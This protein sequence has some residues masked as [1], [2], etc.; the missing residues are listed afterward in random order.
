VAPPRTRLRATCGTRRVC[1]H[2]PCGW[3]VARRRR[4]RLGSRD[5]CRRRDSNSRHADYDSASLW[6]SH[7]KTRPRWT[8]SWT[9][10]RSR[11]TLPAVRRRERTGR[12]RPHHFRGQSPRR[13]RTGDNPRPGVPRPWTR[14]RRLALCPLPTPPTRR[15]VHLGTIS[16]TRSGRSEQPGTRSPHHDAKRVARAITDLAAG[17]LA[18]A[19]SRGGRPHAAGYWISRRTTDMNRMTPATTHPPMITSR[20][21]PGARRSS[22]RLAR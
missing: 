3:S 9:Q 16:R 13:R 5:R 8:R 18:L 15:T 22:V 19:E 14:R 10:S 11:A 17:V 1:G 2:T 6:L 12:R 20:P 21:G 4:P 7:R